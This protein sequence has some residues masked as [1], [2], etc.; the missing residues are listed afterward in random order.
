MNNILT[1]INELEIKLRSLRPLNK[2]ELKR[3]RDEF[4]IETIIR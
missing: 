3:L 1:E 4:I 2:S